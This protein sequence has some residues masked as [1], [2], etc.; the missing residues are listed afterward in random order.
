MKKRTYPMANHLNGV[1]DLLKIRENTDKQRRNA[2]HKGN[3]ALAISVFALAV[4]L[5][6]LAARVIEKFALLR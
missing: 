6:L 3:I 5:L 4:S 2:K 1:D